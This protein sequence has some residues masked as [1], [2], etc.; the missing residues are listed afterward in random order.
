MAGAHELARGR[1]R[2]R[3]LIEFA[4][5]EGWR[6]VRTSGGHLKFTKP[7]CASIYTSS[8]ASDYRADRNARAQLRRAD[9]Q[10]QENGRG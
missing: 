7:G 9:R 5:G 6:V 4:L 2:L 1:E 10:A 3:A 8:T